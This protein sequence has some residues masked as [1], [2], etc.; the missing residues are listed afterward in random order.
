MVEKRERRRRDGST[1]AVWRVRWYD[2]TSAECSIVRSDGNPAASRSV[3]G[4]ALTSGR[5]LRA[6]QPVRP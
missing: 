6:T 5:R 2:E 3:L 4:R 1:Y